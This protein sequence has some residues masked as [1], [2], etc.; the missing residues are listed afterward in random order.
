MSNGKINVT[1]WNENWHEQTC[2]EVRKVYP[3]GIHNAVAEALKE[4]GIFSVRTATLDMPEHGLTQEV[5][6]QTDVLFWWGH[7]KHGEVSDEIV[8]RIQ[9]RIIE[10]MGLICLHS[11]HFSKIF[12]RMMATDCSL[13]WRE[14]AEKE[15]VWVI[16]PGHPIAEGLGQYFEIEHTEMYGERF[17]IPTPDKV[18][19]IS[20][21]EGGEVF[22]SGVTY[23]RGNGRIF[24]FSPGHE[25]FPIYY[26]KEVKK[27]L[28]NAAKW[29]APRF[30]NREHICPC[31]EPLE[32][33][34]NKKQA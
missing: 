9:K 26:Q 15:R 30:M 23:E 25:T 6:D 11:A 27:V 1:V 17:D 8:D 21:Y 3:D 29:A 12:K 20:W 24:Y 10:G 4:D 19:F 16:E 33:I 5:L 28:T 18:V 13:K 2:E 7:C 34:K 14:W 22:R 31:V 32:P